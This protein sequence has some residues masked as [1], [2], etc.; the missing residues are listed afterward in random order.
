MHVQFG[1]RPG[2]HLRELGAIEL[3]ERAIEEARVLH[4]ALI[5]GE[6]CER[7][8]GGRLQAGRR[9]EGGFQVAAELPLRV[10]NPQ[11]FD[12]PDLPENREDSR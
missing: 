10:L 2:A 3:A 9:P 8:A 5:A 7:G 4:P 6:R 1:A 12:D 11:R